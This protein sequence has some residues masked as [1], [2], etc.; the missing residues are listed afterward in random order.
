MRRSRLLPLVILAIASCNWLSLARN[1][2]TYRELQRGETGNL[3]ARDSLIY[4]TLAEDGWTI[5]GAGSGKRLA[6]IPPPAGS[7]SVDDLALSDGLLFVLDARPPGYVSVYSLDDPL[8]PRLLSPPRA[9]PVGPFAGVAA[10]SGVCIV[11]GGTSELTVWHY[12]TLGLGAA[13]LA[14]ADLGRGQPDVLL[15]D[16]G[17][18]AYVSTHYWGPYF[19]LDVVT[20]DGSEVRAAAELEIDGAGFTSGGA[21]PANFPIEAALFGR[22]TVL[23]AHAG[24]VS[25]VDV[26][27]PDRPLL[28]ATIDVGGPAVNVDTHGNAVAVAVAG[29]APALVFLDIG[30]GSATLARRIPLPPGTLPAGVALT[31]TQAAVALADRGIQRFER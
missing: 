7:E 22:D 24:G 8:R 31:A 13:P 18:H 14:T 23:V 26:R 9:V 10:A 16:D 19:G 5:V 27:V 28:R 1:A 4:A 11:S 3:A 29:T 2:L 17:R 21:K 20:V 12:D 15:A 25:I 30:N 6:T